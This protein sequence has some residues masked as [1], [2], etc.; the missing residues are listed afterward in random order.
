MATTALDTILAVSSLS[1]EFRT[2]ERVVAAVRDVS[3][4]VGRGETIAA[5]VVYFSLRIGTSIIT[6]AS[7]SF[8]G[9]G[10]QPPTPEWGAMLNEARGHD[11]LAA[12]RALPQLGHLP[13]RARVQP[14]GRR[15]A[16]RARSEDRPPMTPPLRRG[17]PWVCGAGD[18]G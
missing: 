17:R 6:A 8:I 5:V 10:A 13:D 3:F 9:M 7:L 12:R 18:P 4:S 15:L 1:V 11:D 14:P 2:S 16:R